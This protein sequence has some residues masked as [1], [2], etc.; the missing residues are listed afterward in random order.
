MHKP[1]LAFALVAFL[2]A[3]LPGLG[4]EAQ[5]N[6]KSLAAIAQRDGY[7]LRWLLPDRAVQLYRPGVIIVIRPGARMY[8]VNDR[9]EFADAAPFYVN[10]DMLI[11]TALAARLGHLAAS[12]AVYRPPHTGQFVAHGQA[13]GSGALTLDVRR[14]PGAEALRVSGHAPSSA[15]VTITLLATI[16][17]DLPTVVLSRNDLQPD[18][19]GRFD[20]AISVA[21]DYL[22]D[23][24]VQ[25]LATAPGAMPAQTVF[26]PGP[27]NAGVNVPFDKPYCPNNVCP[28]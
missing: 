4:V 19:N 16:S 12:T 28:L 15:P 20:A 6:D 13:T 1:I 17:Q 5:T 2:I 27:P 22:R 8:E 7:T 23:T 18:S 11:S 26:T 3:A 14:E 9:V 24:I 10:G 21:P 25:V